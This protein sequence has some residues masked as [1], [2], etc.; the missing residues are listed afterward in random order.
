[1]NRPVGLMLAV[2]FVLVGQS[3]HAQLPAVGQLPANGGFGMDYAQP[4]PSNTYVL[5][6]WWMVQAT[7]SVGS[8]LPPSNQVQSAPVVVQ[9][10]NPR[11]MTRAA[12]SLS[13][14]NARAVN[15]VGAPAATA[16]PSGSLYWPAT[17]MPLYS[18]E[19]RYAAYGQGYGVSPYG[20]VDYGAQY[21]GLYW[22]N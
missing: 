4:V 2:M 1:M 17:S 11:R 22:G 10:A 3:A 5:D 21:K 12:R 6:R 13:R 16:L 18:P 20:S 19:Q 8:A 9:P 7:P 15:R 14:M